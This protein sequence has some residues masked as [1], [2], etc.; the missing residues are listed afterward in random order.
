[1]ESKN[2]TVNGHNL[3]EMSIKPYVQYGVGIQKT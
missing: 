1:M 2:S 3:P